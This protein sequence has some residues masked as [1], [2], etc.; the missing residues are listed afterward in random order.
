[1]RKQLALLRPLKGTWWLSNKKLLA[2]MLRELSSLFLA[3]YTI[4]LSFWLLELS[5][6]EGPFT[7]FSMLVWSSPFVV[8]SLVMLA[9]SL[10]HSLT[11][12]DLTSRVQRIRA[13]TALIDNRLV[14]VGNVVGWVALSYVIAVV[15]LG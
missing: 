15:L 6:G 13:G 4:V 1:M 12:F 7:Q 14:L 11:W 2:Y 8:A 5:K 10:Y 9:F 3:S